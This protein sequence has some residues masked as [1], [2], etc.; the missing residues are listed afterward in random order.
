MRLL[1]LD[2][3]W[4][5]AAAGVWLALAVLLFSMQTKGN[6]AECLSIWRF[7]AVGSLRWLRGLVS[8]SHQVPDA[9][10][11]ARQLSDVLQIPLVDAELSLQL[12][13]AF[14]NPTADAKLNGE[15]VDLLC[16]SA[17]RNETWRAQAS[18]C[19]RKLE[20]HG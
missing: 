14:F 8:G 1:G 9:Q 3:V 5:M 15:A 16:S 17:P 4:L 18:E 13:G 10:A 6:V 2:S 20:A 19:C 11:T 12:S 7:A